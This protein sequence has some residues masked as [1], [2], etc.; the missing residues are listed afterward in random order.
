ML[1]W[2]LRW[3]AWRNRMLA[4]QR[5][6]DWAAA[7]PGIRRIARSRASRAF[8]L[9]AGF[10][11][12]QVLLAAVEGGALDLLASGPT[13][14]R[15][16]AERTGLSRDAAECL[17]RAMTALGLAEEAAPDLWVLG[18]QGAV[19]QADRG[20]QAMTRHHRLLYN[21]L[22][23]PLALLR[24]DRTEPTALSDFWTYA[25][26]T[27]EGAAAVTPYSELMGASQSMIGREV[28]DAYDFGRHRGVLDVGGGHGGFV[29]RLAAKYRRLR[30]GVF[31]LPEV[32][33][34][35][36]ARLAVNGLAGRV[37]VHAGDFFRD[38]IPDGYD[39]ATLIRIIHDHDDAR[40]L[41]LLTAIRR[42]LPEGGRL[43]VVEP[44]S[45]IRGAEAMAAYFAMYLWA[46]G[47]G[48][49]RRAEEIGALLREAGFT[50]WTLRR[51]RQPIVA[52]VIVAGT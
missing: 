49:P 43:I 14:L 30:L 6:Q 13:N 33:T 17:I 36:S 47:S 41:Q 50:S 19:L 44:M 2:K 38:S 11:Y 45:S 39:C 3:I 4:S 46:M 37:A 7:I 10:A 22:T 16:L 5:F 51:T 27:P 23:D 31:D 12:S 26:G 32:V 1:T 25:R 35:T 40:V 42:S 9:V 52:S 29:S 20:V 21:D 24:R 15:A 28:V 8:D 48:R 34:T 18:Q